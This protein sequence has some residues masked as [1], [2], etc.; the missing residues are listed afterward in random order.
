[1]IKY[2]AYEINVMKNGNPGP[3]YFIMSSTLRVMYLEIRWF[4][5]K[6]SVSLLISLK[7]MPS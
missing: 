7:G 4:D 5:W 6:A 2:T 1:M 3:E